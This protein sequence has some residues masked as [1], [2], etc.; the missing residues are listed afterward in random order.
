ML[1]LR[2]RTVIC[3]TRC[4]IRLAEIFKTNKARELNFKRY[5]YFKIVQETQ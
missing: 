3:G 5:V 1:K 2:L 4:E